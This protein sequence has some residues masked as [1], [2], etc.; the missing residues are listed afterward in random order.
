VRTQ[1]GKSNTP[2][3]TT[4][5]IRKPKFYWDILIGGG[6]YAVSG[7]FG[8][9]GRQDPVSCP[10]DQRVLTALLEEESEISKYYY[11]LFL[12]VE[13]SAVWILLSYLLYSAE[14]ESTFCN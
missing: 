8:K 3:R 6:E 4:G 10:V 7:R 13:G 2:S 9:R 5:L 14:F 12:Q 1:S 11:S